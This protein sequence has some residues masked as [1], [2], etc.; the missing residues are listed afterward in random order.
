[1]IL[2]Q[3][4]VERITL[5]LSQIKE[6]YMVVVAM[7]SGNLEFLIQSCPQKDLL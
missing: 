3:Y 7:N 1:M 2:N 6:R 4:R 5:S